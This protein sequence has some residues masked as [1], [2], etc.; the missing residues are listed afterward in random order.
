[1]MVVREM[2]SYRERRFSEALLCIYLRI[3][4]TSRVF[5]VLDI[6]SGEVLQVASYIQQKEYFA[7]PQYYLASHY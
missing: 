6:C 3:R 5:S 2:Q 4:L 1:M 7:I